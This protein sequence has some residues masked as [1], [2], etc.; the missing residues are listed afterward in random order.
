MAEYLRTTEQKVNAVVSTAMMAG[1]DEGRV[2]AAMA[3]TVG[4]V[5]IAL[6]REEKRLGK[7]V[8]GVKRQ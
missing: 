5:R 1:V 3:P 8:N 4:A 7:Q 6:K 2:R